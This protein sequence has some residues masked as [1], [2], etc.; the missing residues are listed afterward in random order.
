[1][2]DIKFLS[3]GTKLERTFNRYGQRTTAMMPETV[4]RL[5]Y[6][7]SGRMIEVDLNE[8]QLLQLMVSAAQQME[9]IIKARR[10]PDG[11]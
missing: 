2:A 5:A 6:E 9:R 11:L 8:D 4:I 7:K 1:M 3:L 10:N